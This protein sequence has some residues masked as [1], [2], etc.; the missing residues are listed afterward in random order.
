M[1]DLIDR[2]AALDFKV[3]HGLNENGILYVPY[4]DVKKHLEQLPSAQPTQLNTPNTLEALDCISRQAALNPNFYVSSPRG[5]KWIIADTLN[6]YREYIKKLPS[7]ERHGKWL[8]GYGFA[9]NYYDCF[10]CDQC[11]KES[12]AKTNYCQNCGARMDGEQ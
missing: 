4:A 11:K 1:K 5:T 10:V 3:S 9:G 6:A 8:D 7:A 12:M 2:Q